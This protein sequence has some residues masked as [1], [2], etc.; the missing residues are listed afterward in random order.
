MG[1][2]QHSKDRLFI[3]ATEWAQQ[4]GGKKRKASGSEMRPLPFDHCA[5]TLSPFSN[6]CLLPNNTGVVFDFENIVEYLKTHGCDPVTGQAMTTKDIIRL[7][8][9][10]NAEGDWQC[11][12]TNKVFTASSHIVAIRT[13]GNVYSYNA[14]EE[15]NLRPKSFFD[16]IDGTKFS[17]SDIIT[18]QD[19][20]NPDIMSQRDI[21]NF[22]HLEQVRNDAQETK[23]HESRVRHS[24]ASESVMKEIERVRASEQGLKKATTEEILNGRETALADDVRRFLLLKPTTTDVNPGQVNTD[25][26][27]GM[28]FTSTSS[29]SH[30]SNQTRLASPEEIREARWKIMRKVSY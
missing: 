26:R 2:N 1:K 22:K 20:Q 13:T 14:V 12:I 7:H 9:D 3:T 10:K 8:M 16:L 5:L 25:G 27:A 24:T 4:Y 28:S 11:P 29:L 21:N 19:P 23:K 15:L 30:T 18:I 17:R 6:P